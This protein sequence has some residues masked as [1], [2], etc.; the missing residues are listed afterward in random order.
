MQREHQ[1]TLS[2][3]HNEIAQL[4]QKC[5]DM[6]FLLAMQTETS[7]LAEQQKETI[8]RL[9][10]DCDSL[11]CCRNSLQSQL[12]ESQQREAELESQISWEKLQH[13]NLVASLQRQLEQRDVSILKLK[14]D[15]ETNSEVAKI[16]AHVK[17]IYLEN[18]SSVQNT[19]Q[20]VSRRARSPLG[21]RIR[22]RSRPRTREGASEASDDS[23]ES[24]SSLFSSLTEERERTDSSAVPQPAQYLSPGSGP[25]GS[26]SHPAQY[27]SPAS[28][29]KQERR[30]QVRAQ[31]FRHHT[32]LSDDTSYYSFSAPPVSVSARP[33]GRR[34]T[35]PIDYKAPVA[36]LP[37]LA[38]EGDSGPESLTL[39]SSPLGESS[40]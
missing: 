6:Q 13:D 22:R 24:Y 25:P 40:L 30:A 19:I 1:A 35:L 23:L 16:Q 20:D 32:K 11:Q 38:R 10:S 17:Q 36:T 37:Y 34:S 31:V 15:L 18:S 14:K 26:L 12:S 7:N 3:L 4:T 9:Q 33:L 29:E 39:L 8:K 5:S 21:I 2:G 27:L 28:E